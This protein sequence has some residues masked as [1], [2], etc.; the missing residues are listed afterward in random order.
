MLKGLFEENNFGVKAL[1]HR[2]R[3]FLTHAEVQKWSE[4]YISVGTRTWVTSHVDVEAYFCQPTYLSALYGVELDTA[5]AWVEEAVALVKDRKRS[6][7][8]EHT[9]ELQS[10][11]R[12]SYAVF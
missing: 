4:R 11:M 12:I 9:S 7:S 5:Q 1:I 6:R 8:E 10:L 2:D 3:D